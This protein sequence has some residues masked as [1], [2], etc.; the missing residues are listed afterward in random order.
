[1]NFIEEIQPTFVSA[2]I[3]TPYPGTGFINGQYDAFSD[4]AIDAANHHSLEYIAGSI[5]K[6]EL[7]R[8]MNF[9]DNYNTQSKLNLARK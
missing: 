2:A 1:M 8:F 6:E 9:A 5:P 3:Y 7:I 4:H